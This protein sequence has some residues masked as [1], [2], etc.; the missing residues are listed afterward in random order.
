MDIYKALAYA[1]G[2]MSLPLTEMGNTLKNN[3]HIYV[4]NW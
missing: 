4:E 2:G 1:S 3:A